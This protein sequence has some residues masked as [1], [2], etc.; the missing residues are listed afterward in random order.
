MIF[1]FYDGYVLI[2]VKW[3]TFYFIK[4]LVCKGKF[5]LY[6]HHGGEFTHIGGARFYV[7]VLILKMMDSM[8]ISLGIWMLLER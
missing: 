3:L 2:Q 8:L 7:G 4:F 5:A 1:N 6:F